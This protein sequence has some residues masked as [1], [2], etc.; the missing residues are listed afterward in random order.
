M[1][2]RLRLARHGQKHTPYYHIVAVNASKRR[3]ARPLEKLGEYDPIPRAGPSERLEKKV[4]WNAERIKYWLGVGAEPTE[5]VVKLL[6]KVSGCPGNNGL[7]DGTECIY[8]VRSLLLI[9]KAAVLLSL[10]LPSETVSYADHYR[11][12]SSR[13]HTN[14]NHTGPRRTSPV[15]LQH[16][17]RRHLL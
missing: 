10:G 8:M 4:E 14:G 15:A 16:F 2:V 13:G 17:L 9:R 7:Q 5:T 11:A 6:E 1:P 12:A 3:D